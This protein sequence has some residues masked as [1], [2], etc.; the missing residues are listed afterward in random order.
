MKTLLRRAFAGFGALLAAGCDE[1]TVITRVDDLGLS[2][3]W[4]VSVGSGGLPVE[5]HGAPFAGVR[6]EEVAARLQFPSGNLHD[7]RFRLVQPGE[8]GN[9]LVLVFNRTGAPDGYGDCLRTTEAATRE[10]AGPGFDVTAT[11]CT[12]ERAL[13]T[14]FMEAP[15]ARADDPDAFL[16]AM[17]LL[18]KT[19][20]EVNGPLT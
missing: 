2:R 19:I 8:T 9:R 18:L 17:R 6:R 7:V 11:F 3:S 5:V 12:G 16:R 14:G 20:T 1:P 4:I 15:K 13:A 10:S